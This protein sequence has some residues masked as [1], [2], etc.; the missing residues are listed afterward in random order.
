MSRQL[1]LALSLAC[2]EISDETGDY[3]FICDEDELCDAL[4]EAVKDVLSD[5]DIQRKLNINTNKKLTA[6]FLQ[7]KDSTEDAI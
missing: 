1:E 3:D 4:W 5:N 7:H 2:D 6:S